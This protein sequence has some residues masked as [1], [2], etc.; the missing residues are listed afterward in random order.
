MEISHEDTYYWQGKI[1][2]QSKAVLICPVNVLHAVLLSSVGSCELETVS[3]TRPVHGLDRDG[4]TTAWGEMPRRRQQTAC[5]DPCAL[6]TYGVV[7]QRIRLLRVHARFVDKRY[8][9]PGHVRIPKNIQ[10][11]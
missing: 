5:V 9:L 1:F 2:R 6:L 10:M 8:S 3:G 4:L 7:N 11:P